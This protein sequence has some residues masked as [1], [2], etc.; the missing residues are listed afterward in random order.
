MPQLPADVPF[1]IGYAGY[2][3]W[4]G[5]TKDVAARGGLATSMPEQ[6]GKY[7]GLPAARYPSSVIAS[8]RMGEPLAWT[9]GKLFGYYLAP[10]SILLLDTIHQAAVKLAIAEG[11]V[12]EVAEGFAQVVLVSAVLGVGLLAYLATSRR[13]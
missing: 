7:E 10:K 11:K 3:T 8:R 1:G 4:L 9:N 6:A 13:K 12:A 2:P 5:W